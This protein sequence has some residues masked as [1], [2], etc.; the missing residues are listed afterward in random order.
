MESITKLLQQVLPHHNVAVDQA[1]ITGIDEK[2]IK[3][4]QI[5]GIPEGALL[6]MDFDAYGSFFYAYDI[7]TTIGFGQ[8]YPMT[9]AGKFWT[10][11]LTMLGCPLI[12]YFSQLVGDKIR[13]ISNWLKQLICHILGISN[14]GKAFVVLGIELVGCV[15]YL[16]IPAIVLCFQ[17]PGWTY[18]DSVYFAVN[19]LST[20]GLGDYVAA[21]NK[22]SVALGFYRLIHFI[23]LVLGL[24]WWDAYQTDCID[25][26]QSI[27]HFCLSPFRCCRLKRRQSARGREDEDQ[28]TL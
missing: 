12:V 18:F 20:T 25:R 28:M 11:I 1:E 27:L 23:W 15:F 14:I 21:E 16:F 9:N 5:S 24:A 19:A 17:E 26:I 4:K 10:T 22:D 7:I 6:R 8:R 13:K 3:I 2:L